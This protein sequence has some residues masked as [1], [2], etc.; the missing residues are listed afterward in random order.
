M[1]NIAKTK[2]GQRTI[3]LLFAVFG[4]FLYAAGIN[5]FI[6]PEGLYTGG[7]MGICQLIRTVLVDYLHI[8]F[9]N[10]DFAG[11]IYYVINIPLFLIAIKK[12]GKIFFIKTVICVTTASLFLTLV[13]SP[14][15]PILS[16]DVLASCII[17]G[18]ISGVGSGVT[19]KMG[20]STGG[21]DIVGILMIR[22]KKDFSVGK[23]NLLVNIALYGICLFLFDVPVVLYSIIYAAIFSISIDRMYSQ[24]IN[25]EATIITKCA[26]E[27]MQQ[28][29]FSRL[30]RGITKWKSLGAYTNE[31]SEVL[32]IM[33]SKYEVNQLKSIV[34][35]YDS[36]AFIVIN[37]GVS[38]DGNYLKKL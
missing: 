6:V 31:E 28:E 21:M 15:L 1:E 11:V 16:E 27:E 17:G 23:I 2:N 38:V 33:L 26:P 34:K 29:I 14:P 30:G 9:G 32:Y 10:I 8:P 19:L 37:E 18:I 35:K 24:N 22:R 12:F 20:G 36:G 5:L 3:R 7:V 4:T 25:V 13:P